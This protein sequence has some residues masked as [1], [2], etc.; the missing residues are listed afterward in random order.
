MND[1]ERNESLSIGHRMNINRRSLLTAVSLVRLPN[2]LEKLSNFLRINI[3]E[4]TRNS[5]IEM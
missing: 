2:I 5:D 4:E 1:N 3:C